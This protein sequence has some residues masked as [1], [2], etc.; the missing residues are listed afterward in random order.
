MNNYLLVYCVPFFVA[1]FGAIGGG[2]WDEE[3][4]TVINYK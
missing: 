4:P 2:R 3:Q 1:G